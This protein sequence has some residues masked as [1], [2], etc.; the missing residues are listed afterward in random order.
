MILEFLLSWL[1]AMPIKSVHMLA[2]VC[3]S[4]FLT[5]AVFKSLSFENNSNDLRELPT[6]LASLSVK[7]N[8]TR[9]G[10]LASKH[11][12]EQVNHSKQPK[13]SK[14]MREVQRK[15]LKEIRSEQRAREN[16]A[17]KLAEENYRDK[18]FSLIDLEKRRTNTIESIEKQSRS[19]DHLRALEDIENFEVDGNRIRGKTA[20][21]LSEIS[22]QRLNDEEN[23][24]LSLLRYSRLGTMGLNANSG[25]T[26]GDGYIPQFSPAPGNW[27]NTDT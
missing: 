10:P 4:S 9:R 19:R 24:D 5:F 8:P 23:A 13:W 17:K 2:L 7:T 20:K 11:R 18:I 25:E 6:L 16:S 14:Y 21:K 26:V 3:I 22:A 1:A 12:L 15:V 27:L